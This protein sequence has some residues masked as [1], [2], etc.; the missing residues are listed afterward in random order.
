MNHDILKTVIYDQHEIIRSFN[1]VSR[2]YDFD[3]NANYVVIG[4][5]RAG[6]ST[7]L[8]KIVQDFKMSA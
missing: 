7:L 2:E 5:R 4:L 6:K 1:I 8:Y 3:I